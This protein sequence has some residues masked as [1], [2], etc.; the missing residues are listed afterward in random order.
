MT[1]DVLKSPAVPLLLQLEADGFELVTV[2]NRLL[3]R[4]V[5][6]LPLDGRAQLT[7][8]R[9]ELV[10]LLRICDASVQA[11]RAVFAFQLGQAL[12]VGR[13]AMREGLPYVAGQCFS[14]GDALAHPGFGRCWRCALA[15]RLAAG[16]SI[17]SVVADIYDQQRTVA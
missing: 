9:Q 3:V 11:R 5:E 2:E 6:R 17:G 4:P 12:S 16:V 15:W 1:G 10:T 7:T 14:C 8:Y 13:L